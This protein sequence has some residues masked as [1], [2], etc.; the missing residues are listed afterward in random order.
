M[1]AVQTAEIRFERVSFGYS[2]PAGPQVLNDLSFTVGAGERVAVVGGSGA[3]KSTL[4]RLLYKFHEPGAG[5]ICLA[6]QDITSVSGQSVFT[7]GSMK[8]YLVKLPRDN[9]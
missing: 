6:G 9:S 1:T 2:G 8:T 3:G 5:R 7:S 4:V